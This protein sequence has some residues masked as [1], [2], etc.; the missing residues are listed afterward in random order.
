MVYAIT[1]TPVAAHM[2][3]DTEWMADGWCV[4]RAHLFASADLD[5]RLLAASKCRTACPVQ[6]ECL[7]YV[8]AEFGRNQPQEIW[9]GMTA[10]QRRKLLA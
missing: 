4:E 8:L 6:A 2:M 9:A 10:A 7:A 3:R 1:E 5:D